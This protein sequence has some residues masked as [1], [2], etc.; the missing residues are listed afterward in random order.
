MLRQQL[1]NSQ[2]IPVLLQFGSVCGEKGDLFPS[3]EEIESSYNFDYTSQRI[4]EKIEC[5]GPTWLWVSTGKGDRQ[6]RR[7]VD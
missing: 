7:R 2:M 5:K 6:E 1:R 4:A 3:V